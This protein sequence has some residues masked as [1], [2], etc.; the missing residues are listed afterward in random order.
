MLPPELLFT[1][2]ICTKSF[3]GRG[4]APDPTGGAH[5]ASPDPL[6]GSGVGPSGKGEEKGRGK[7]EGMKGRRGEV[8]GKGE[9]K[10]GGD[11]MP[12]N[13]RIMST[14][15]VERQ[16]LKSQLKRFRDPTLGL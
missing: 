9:R 4:F 13:V 15:L 14:P 12:P 11:R 16:K 3:V 7:R 1:A 6:A 10:G 5:S 2:Q 8:K